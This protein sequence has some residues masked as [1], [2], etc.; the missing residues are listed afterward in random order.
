MANDTR[1][2]LPAGL[3]NFRFVLKAIVDQIKTVELER[4]GM[5]LSNTELD[6]N[7]ALNTDTAA[8]LTNIDLDIASALNTLAALH[9][10]AHIEIAV[11]EILHDTVERSGA[12]RQV[13]TDART[14]LTSSP[15][16][17]GHW[18]INL[19]IELPFI[20]ALAQ[21]YA[22]Q[23]ESV[24]GTN[25]PT[26]H[27]ARGAESPA[28]VL[29]PDKTWHGL[30][31]DGTF[32]TVPPLAPSQ[33]MKPTSRTMLPP[34]RRAPPLPLQGDS[35]A[36]FAAR[37]GDFVPTMGIDHIPTTQELNNFLFNYAGPNAP[38]GELRVGEL[39]KLLQYLITYKQYRPDAQL[40]LTQLRQATGVDN[41]NKRTGQIIQG[42]RLRG[43]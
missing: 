40:D 31:S 16:L 29:G 28:K 22:A 11:Q 6:R 20:R 27:A 12:F 10:T 42:T 2:S 35:D 24:Q 3:N 17:P 13:I 8:M 30:M 23:A 38:G 14:Y 21:E 39:L 36:N 1:S 34:P 5:M 26:P 32:R 33:Q 7:A 15:H 37:Y 4:I 43:G 19:R 18:Q 41:Y 25:T 9:N